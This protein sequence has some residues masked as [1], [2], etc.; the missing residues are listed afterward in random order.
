MQ[1]PN[2]KNQNYGLAMRC[3]NT[4]SNI[5]HFGFYILTLSTGGTI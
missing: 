3:I 1:K 4:N 2:L 5:L